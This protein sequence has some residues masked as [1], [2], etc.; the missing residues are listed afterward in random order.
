MEI[1]KVIYLLS[2]EP[3]QGK[4]I[5]ANEFECDILS[6]DELMCQYYDSLT[7][8]QQRGYFSVTSIFKYFEQVHI[9]N[10]LEWIFNKIDKFLESEKNELLIDGWVL[11][12]YKDMIKLKYPDIEICY[13]IVYKY[14]CYINGVLFKNKELGEIKQ[15][16]VEPIK[17]YING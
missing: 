6:L 2:G 3:K 12:F 16:I 15:N 9:N 5:I 8:M 4:S 10:F 17:K 7:G 1:K 13:I 14:S 11:F